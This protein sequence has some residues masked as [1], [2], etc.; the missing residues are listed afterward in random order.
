MSITIPKLDRRL[1]MRHFLPWAAIA[2]MPFPAFGQPLPVVDINGIPQLAASIASALGGK[3]VTVMPF[4][5]FDNVT[6]DESESLSRELQTRLFGTKR[7]RIVT[8]DM[9]DLEG[10]YA[11]LKLGE[12]GVI[13]PSTVS[14]LRKIVGI[15][16]LITG[17]ISRNVSPGIIYCNVVEIST[18]VIH[19]AWVVQ[20]VR[21]VASVQPRVLTTHALQFTL[22]AG[23]TGL[24]INPALPRSL[25]AHD[26][27]HID[28]VRY[29]PFLMGFAGSTPLDRV[30]SHLSEIE[31]GVARRHTDGSI[32]FIGAYAI[33][34]PISS[35]GRFEI[36]QVNDTRPSS[37]GSFVY[38]Q[39]VRVGPAHA[40]RTGFSLHPQK[41]R[42]R[43][44][45]VHGFFNLGIWDMT[46]EK[47]WSRF[48]TDQPEFTAEVRGVELSPRGR[49]SF[50]KSGYS[51]H[52]S[53]GWTLIRFGYESAVG[54]PSHNASGWSVGTG[55]GT[56]FRLN[57]ASSSQSNGSRLSH[58]RHQS[59]ER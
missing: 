52:I 6:T 2:L 41:W 50:V 31:A 5:E 51:F 43:G 32:G 20:I 25:T 17:Y 35:R 18:S 28:D 30:S 8:R 19:S 34:F 9:A 12:T 10:I 13:D 15:D 11:E 24:R 27:N 39:V 42:T 47:G 53:G 7:L 48:A 46:F 58:Y 59:V 14:S 45:E 3:T 54:L 40:F 57:A 37:L 29:P 21:H 56:R 49:L 38:S 26:S 16:F 33:D 22:S 1:R 4:R 36:Q 23:Y 55:V 44:I